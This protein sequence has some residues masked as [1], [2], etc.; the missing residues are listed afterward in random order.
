M[1]GGG[2]DRNHVPVQVRP[3]RLAMHHQHRLGI[4]LAFVQIMHAQ[5]AHV[6][7]VGLERVIQQSFET[8]IR[9]AQKI[10]GSS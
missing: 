9:S 3:G 1:A 10:H 8:G 2:A 6:R 4:R 5:T 7:I